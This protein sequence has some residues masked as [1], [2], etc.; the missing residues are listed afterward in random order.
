MSMT[1]E[2]RDARLTDYLEGELPQEIRLDVDAR[3]EADP[4]F[5][6]EVEEARAGRHL[7]RQLD[8]KPVPPHFAQKVQRKAKRVSRPAHI[9]SRNVLGFGL[10]VEVFAIIAGAVMA[11]LY[12]FGEVAPP[13]L[14]VQLH[15]TPLPITEPASTPPAG[16]QPTSEAP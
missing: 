2:T 14:P 16:A 15:E 12:L 3:L 1:E 10:S 7:L 11:A 13:K 9:S 6:R 4:D 5:A 8:A